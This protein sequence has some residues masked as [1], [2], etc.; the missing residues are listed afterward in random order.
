MSDIIVSIF[1]EYLHLVKLMGIKYHQYNSLHGLNL[2]DRM[3]VFKM[4]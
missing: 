2:H 3:R 1:N 4:N